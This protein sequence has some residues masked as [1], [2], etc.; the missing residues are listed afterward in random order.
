[1]SDHLDGPRS[2]GDPAV[3]CTDLCAFTSPEN[4]A[5]TVLTMDVFASAGTSAV[6]SDAAN[7]AIVLRSV[8]VAGLGDAAKFQAG[9][10]EIRFKP[11]E[12]NVDAKPIHRGTCTLPDGRA[13]SCIV[14][15]ERGASTPDGMFRVFA[16]LESLQTR[17]GPL[18]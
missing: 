9:E 15:D 17:F 11:T 18:K 7:H 2:I 6:F 13:L 5:R 1:V 8:T 4:S 3:D 10:S 16:G 14:N 12:A